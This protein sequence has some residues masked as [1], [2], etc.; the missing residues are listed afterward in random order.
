MDF[1]DKNIFNNII[2][3]KI[4]LFIN[5]LN[6]ILM[7]TTIIAYA[8]II[9]GALSLSLSPRF[10][11]KNKIISIVLKVIASISIAIALI[12]GF[13]SSCDTKV[14][15]IS[16][17]LSIGETYLLGL[18]CA[19]ALYPKQTYSLCYEAVKN[20]F[21]PLINSWHPWIGHCCLVCIASIF[22]LML[23]ITITFMPIIYG[24][25][26]IATAFT[27]FISMLILTIIL[28]ILVLC[29]LIQRWI[30]WITK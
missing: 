7:F 25:I 6:F 3:N 1:I 27:I 12:F 22:L 20:L 30:K 5:Y 29:K 16:I 14:I 10:E 17:F 11:T 13:L 21:T 15:I 4:I 28:V 8:S 24:D 18:T 23:C 2:R 26:L 19:Y 9:I